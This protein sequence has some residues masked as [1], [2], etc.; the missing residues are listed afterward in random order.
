MSWKQTQT[1]AAADE[2]VEV[3]VMFTNEWVAT[4]QPGPDESSSRQ[5]PSPPDLI[6]DS[7]EVSS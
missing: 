2:G 4:H 5:I 1:Q 6:V 7:R 3:I